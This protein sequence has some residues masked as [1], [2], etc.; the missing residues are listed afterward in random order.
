MFINVA[1]KM[2]AGIKT[3]ATFELCGVAKNRYTQRTIFPGNIAD[4]LCFA[5]ARVA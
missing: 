5:V 4:R 1:S 3:N 2:K